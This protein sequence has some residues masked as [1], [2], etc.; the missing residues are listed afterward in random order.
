MIIKNRF[1]SIVMLSTVFTS[2]FAAASTP[3][4]NIPE[5]RWDFTFVVKPLT[6]TSS[7]ERGIR[8]LQ[9]LH[10]D[11]EVYWP[12]LEETTDKIYGIIIRK[13]TQK[14]QLNVEKFSEKLKHYWFKKPNFI[15]LKIKEKFTVDEDCTIENQFFQ[16]ICKKIVPPTKN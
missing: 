15:K 7:Y 8:I 6:T 12:I 13:Q 2:Y 4:I 11:N 10:K 14:H 5:K 1:Y 3:D 16:I 9:P